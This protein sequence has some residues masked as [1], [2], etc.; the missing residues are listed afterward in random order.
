MKIEGKKIRLRKIRISDADFIYQNAQD[1]EITRYSFV[2]PPPFTFE[3]AR[4]FI[5][6]AQREARRKISYQFGIELKNRQKLIGIIG[7]S[8]INYHNKNAN[9]GFWL[10]REYWG[11]GF[12]R[13]ALNLILGFGFKQLKLK[14]IQARVLSGNKPSQKLLEKAGFKLEGR[15]RKKTFFNNQWFDD[16]IYGILEGEYNFPDIR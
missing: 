12:S 15:L 6:K 14:R 8:G 3:Q 13:E 5:R 16:I 7:L 1:K 9:V 11:K 10:A 4:K 2:I